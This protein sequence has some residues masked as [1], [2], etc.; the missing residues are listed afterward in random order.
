MIPPLWNTIRGRLL[1]Y[2]L[3]PLV[4]LLA[5]G[6][7]LDYETGAAPVRDAY[8]HALASAA[9]AVAALAQSGTQSAELARAATA[10]DAL[11]HP[12]ARARA[13]YAVHAGGRHLAGGE[14]QHE[15]RQQVGEQPAAD[16]VPERRDH[17]SGLVVEPVTQAADGADLCCL[18]QLGAQARHDGFDRI[19][20][21]VLGR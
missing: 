1:A 4:L 2:L 10:I 8:D 9:L 6:V 15:R 7:Y 16:G 13:Y 21:Q 20:R 3:P 12:G 19:D 18:A 14:Q 5:A 11:L 17:A